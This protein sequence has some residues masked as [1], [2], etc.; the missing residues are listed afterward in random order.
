MHKLPPTAEIAPPA[1]ALPLWR[2]SL[3]ELMVFMTLAAVD[4]TCWAVHPALGILVT[5]LFVPAM[6]RTLAANRVAQQAEMSP[7]W[8]N[9][10]REFLLSAFLVI[11]GFALFVVVLT[12][13]NFLL[14]LLFGV[15]GAWI[16]MSLSDRSMP[17]LAIY[18][19]FSLVLCVYVQFRFLKHNWP[20]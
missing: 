3:A 5:I 20:R 2:F 11:V 18:F 13:I 4:F 12:G 1:R 7:S 6:F 16:V 8:R 17:F 15:A 14:S 10:V 9:Q 19:V